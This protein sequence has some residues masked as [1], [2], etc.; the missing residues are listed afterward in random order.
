MSPSS[1]PA[2]QKSAPGS[3]RATV[4]GPADDELGSV[5]LGARAASPPS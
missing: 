2:R 5:A 1:T 3:V 4:A